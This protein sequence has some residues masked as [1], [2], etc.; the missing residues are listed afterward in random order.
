MIVNHV[1]VKIVIYNQGT[2][3][4]DAMQGGW[5]CKLLD[6]TQTAG[7]ILQ[8]FW[9][10]WTYM[11]DPGTHAGEE[12]WARRIFAMLVTLIG[13]FF[14]EKLFHRLLDNHLFRTNSML[15]VLLCSLFPSA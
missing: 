8:A 3:Y 5:G 12:T 14:M 15:V 6:Q 13:I 4:I 10:A 1:R 9:D 2:G 11:G 7:M